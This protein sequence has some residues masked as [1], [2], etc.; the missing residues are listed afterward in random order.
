MET[1][2]LREILM[3][4]EKR[5]Y[6]AA[7]D[8]LFISTSALSRHV[9]AVEKR[10]GVPLFSRNSRSV[11]LTRYGELLIP[12]AQEMVKAEDK[13]LEALDR[14]RRADGGNLRIGTFFGVSAF[15]V[16]TRIAQFLRE[17]QD[18]VLAVHHEANSRLLEMLRC[19][20]Y[21]MVILQE[22]EPAV[23]DEF[24]RLTVSVDALGVALRSSH[25]LAEAGS[26]RLT[27]LRDEIFLMAPEHSV[28]H[29][30]TMRAFQ[31]ADHMPRQSQLEISGV[32]VM[33][34]VEQGL[35]IALVQQKMA[36]AQNC[37]D[38][39]VVPL[40]PAEL[41]WVRLAWDPEKLSR[42]GQRFLQFL[43]GNGV[44]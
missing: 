37:T 43:K 5:S 6:T 40:Q 28:L 14:T 39:V 41:V 9:S 17:N 8:E 16:M 11:S 4:A 31:R 26:V 22:G 21:D 1:D 34:L 32:G 19:G 23:E 29:D 24:Q 15:G 18:T 30:L 12:C 20:K 7:A 25:M 10:L 27:Q 33:E 2:D 36:Q 13:C 35:G 38:T 42:A 44:E 3:L